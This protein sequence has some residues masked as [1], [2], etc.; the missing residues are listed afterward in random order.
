MGFSRA[1][2]RFN[3]KLGAVVAW[4][5]LIAVLVSA[6]NAIVRK[7]FNTSSNSWLEL[8]WVL[9]GAVFLLCAPWTLLSNE[10]IRIDIVN[11]FFPKRVR[12][13]ID[14]FGHVFFLIP[15]AALIVYL[16]WPYFWLSLLQNEQ[17]TNAGG[18]PV[19]PSKLLI[20]LGFTLLLVQG[21]LGAD[22]AH[23][24]HPRRSAGHGQRRRPPCGG[25][26][27]GRAPA[28]S[29]QGRGGGA[30]PNVARAQPMPTT[31]PSPIP[32]R[33]TEM[34]DFIAQNMAPIMFASLGGVPA[35]RLSGR[36]LAGRRRHHLLHHRRRGCAAVARHHHAVLAAAADPCRIGSTAS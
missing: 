12:D 5:I 4:A 23:R 21:L 11:S 16:G 18:L 34:A 22:Q 27:G 31:Q 32:C 3:T 6:V 35:A 14:V 13:W 1:V 25:G 36:F 2:D 9:F 28:S 30:G 19:Y 20:P 26:G 33:S 17:S 24:H 7:V 15:V 29:G 10:H 8:Q